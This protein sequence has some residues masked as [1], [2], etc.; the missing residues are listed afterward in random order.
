MLR[1]NWIKTIIMKTISWIGWVSFG[2][3]AL[4][5]LLAVISLLIGRNIFGFG[6]VVNYFHAASTFFLAAIA[7]F[8][9]AY[10]CNCGKE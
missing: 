1:K 5:V 4:I 3:G 8:I 7:I 10:R 2:A 6:H 9:F